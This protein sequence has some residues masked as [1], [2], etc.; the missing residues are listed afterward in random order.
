[1][2]DAQGKTRQNDIPDYYVYKDGDQWMKTSKATTREINDWLFRRTGTFNTQGRSFY[3]QWNAP[4]FMTTR[5]VA[6]RIT[7]DGQR[8]ARWSWVI[9]DHDKNHRDCRP[10]GNGECARQ[11]LRTLGYDPKVRMWTLDELPNIATP[12]QMRII[13]N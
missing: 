5:R 10:L 13:R 11:A 1:M 3:P 6:W 4:D 8:V 7:E 9:A 2:I 12:E